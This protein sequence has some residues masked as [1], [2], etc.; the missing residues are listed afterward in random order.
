MK[1]Q[2]AALATRSSQ[3]TPEENR[4]EQA[5]GGHRMKTFD[6]CVYELI[7]IFVDRYEFANYNRILRFLKW[8]PMREG[9][10]QRSRTEKAGG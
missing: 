10:K 4:A 7:S 1:K 9:T 6:F 8:K 2:E 5:G 3:H